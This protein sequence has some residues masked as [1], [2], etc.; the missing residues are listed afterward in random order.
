VDALRFD[1]P[2]Y[3]SRLIL[4]ATKLFSLSHSIAAEFKMKFVGEFNDFS[5]EN[6]NSVVLN[7]HTN[8][9]QFLPPEAVFLVICD[10]FMN[11]L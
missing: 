1:K 9:C 5:F 11:E 6:K 3:F 7:K 2:V 4:L 10:P 8:S